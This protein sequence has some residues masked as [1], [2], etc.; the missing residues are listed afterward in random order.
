M[1]RRKSTRKPRDPRVDPRPGDVLEVTMSW[2]VAPLR[3]T[4][5]G[6]RPGF[7]EWNDSGSWISPRKAV[8]AWWRANAKAADVIAMASGVAAPAEPKADQ[9]KVYRHAGR[10][11]GWRLIHAGDWGGALTAYEK[12]E[13]ALRQ[14]GVRLDAPDGRIVRQAWAPRLRTRW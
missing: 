14:G 2:L 13:A 7:V 3:W 9:Y 5:V 6:R 10:G 4:V 1:A 12:T 11:T 8:I